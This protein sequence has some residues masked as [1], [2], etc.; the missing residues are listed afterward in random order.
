MRALGLPLLFLLPFAAAA[1]AFVRAPTTV[2]A[3]PATSGPLALRRDCHSLLRPCIVLPT[4]GASHVQRAWD[5]Q[6]LPGH[7]HVL[8]ASRPRLGDVL[9][10]RSGGG[11]GNGKGK[12]QQSTPTPPPPAA[13]ADFAQALATEVSVRACVRPCVRASVR[14]WP[15]PCV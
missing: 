8:W 6:R 4:L 3:P 13:A 2:A 5:E 1:A 9:H 14:A 15:A 11:G 7:H 10:P 12:G